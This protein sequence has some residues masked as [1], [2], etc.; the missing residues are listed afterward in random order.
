[1]AEAEKKKDQPA[2]APDLK[3]T[4]PRTY[5]LNKP[6]QSQ[7]EMIST[8]TFREPTAGDLMMLGDTYPVAFNADGTI[9]VNPE[10]M[11]AIMWRLANVSEITIK[12]LSAKDFAG[13]CWAIAPLFLPDVPERVS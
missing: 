5:K 3:E 9:R 6:V 13:L 7:G 1:M 4:G 8:M 2:A 12:A 11:G 10:A